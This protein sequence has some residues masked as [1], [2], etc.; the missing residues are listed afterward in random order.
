MKKNKVYQFFTTNGLLLIILLAFIIRMVYFVSLQPWN[1]EVVNK[2]ILVFDAGGYHSM[3]LGIL[4]EKSFNNFGSC[5]TPLYPM[6]LAACYLISGK[7]IWFALLVQIVINLL[8][9]LFAYKIALEFFSKKIALI[10]LFLLAID[11]HQ[12]ELTVSLLTETLF[13]FIFIVSIYFLCIGLRQKQISRYIVISSCCLGLA[14]LTRPISFL[15][16]I[17]AVLF[18]IYYNSLTNKHVAGRLR[19]ISSMKYSLIYILFFLLIIS[20]WLYRNYIVYNEPK[21]ASISGYTLLFSDI[22]LTE[23]DRT[24]HSFHES[25]AF[26]KQ[27]AYKAGSDT[28]EEQSFKNSQIYTQIAIKYIKNNFSLYCK[29]QLKGMVKM[30]YNFERINDIKTEY[31]LAKY[32]TIGLLVYFGIIYSL[33]ILGIAISIKKIYLINVLFLLIIIYF[34]VITGVSGDARFSVPIMPYIYI[35]CAVGFLPFYTMIKDKFSSVK[36]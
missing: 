8:T 24:G 25:K 29:S 30:F 18:I 13:S 7:A 2:T 1:N 14:T 27:Q 16:P 35:F 9:L 28:A 21:L 31:G 19:F 11:Y 5:R 22:A 3:A 36:K 10:T 34:D 32:K 15:F 33:F 4:S 23:A 12:A 20:P 17:I 26:F 6:F